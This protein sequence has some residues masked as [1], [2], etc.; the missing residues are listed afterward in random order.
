MLELSVVIVEQT[1]KTMQLTWPGSLI[2]ILISN[3][4]LAGTVSNDDNNTDDFNL[5]Q[6]HH[7][8][9]GCNE[10]DDTIEINKYID[11]QDFDAARK[12]FEAKRDLGLCRIVLKNEVGRLQFQYKPI[13]CLA[14]GLA[15]TEPDPE[16][17]RENLCFHARDLDR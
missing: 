1:E 3:M 13:F 15:K 4:P 10:F 14:M 9:F 6:F 7:S 16:H 2:L 11:A 8:V 5:Y 12:S 17:K